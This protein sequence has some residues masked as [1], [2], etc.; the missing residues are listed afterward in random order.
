[1]E[2][3]ESGPFNV[4]SEEMVTINQLA[5]LVMDI[6]GKTL[7]IRNIAGPLGVQGRNSDN[8]LITERLRWCPKRPLR[9]GLEKTYAW[10][11]GQVRRTHSHSVMVAS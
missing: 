11:E 6:A 9:D 4:G 7:P 10:I 3:N 8:R 5:K 2:S 1:M